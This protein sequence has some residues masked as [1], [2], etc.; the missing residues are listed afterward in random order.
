MAGRWPSS[1][2]PSIVTPAEAGV[3]GSSVLG[4][5]G[6][7]DWILR[8]RIED[9]RRW[10]VAMPHSHGNV[11]C[12]PTNASGPCCFSG[13]LVVGRR[14]NPRRDASRHRGARLSRAPRAPSSS[15][16]PLRPLAAPRRPRAGPAPAPV[17]I[18]WPRGSRRSSG[19]WPSGPPARPRSAL[20][21]PCPLPRP[22]SSGVEASGASL[23]PSS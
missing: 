3:Q 8:Y 10:W 15:G 6:R 1:P 19:T 22:P 20:P 7:P 12:S 11:T 9:A 23:P 2:R 14:G 21:P 17:R 13:F 16:Q 18:A 5:T 4:R